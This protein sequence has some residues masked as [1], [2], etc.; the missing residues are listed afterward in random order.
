MSKKSKLIKKLNKEIQDSRKW[1]FIIR[2]SL[3][4]ALIT[5]FLILIWT[6][7]NS[8]YANNNEEYKHLLIKQHYL[9]DINIEKNIDT[10]KII[11]PKLMNEVLLNIENIKYLKNKYLEII[12]LKSKNDLNQ[13][14]KVEI[15]EKLDIVNKKIEKYTYDEIINSTNKKDEYAQLVAIK[16]VLDSIN[17]YNNYSESIN[18]EQLLKN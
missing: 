11:T 3:V 10:K 5:S 14:T 12:K 2:K 18:I 8:S 15:S 9:T 17:E 6:I 16:E 1:V 7:V 4:I 13:L